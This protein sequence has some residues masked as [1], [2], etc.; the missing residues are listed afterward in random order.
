MSSHKFNH[1]VHSAYLKSWEVSGQLRSYDL[2]RNQVNTLSA[3]NT[4]GENYFYAFQPDPLVIRLLTYTF[5]D[6][7]KQAGAG[8]VYARYLH[9]LS[10]A[11]DADSV[12]RNQHFI[13]KQYDRWE[14]RIG[15]AL[16]E[17]RESYPRPL[18]SDT[19]ESL[20]KLYC[21]QHLR[22]PVMRKRLME[23]IRELTYDGIGLNDSQ[24]EDYFK[25]RLVADAQ[26]MASDI[27]AQGFEIVLYH[28]G[29][30]L[31]INSDSPAVQ[32]VYPLKSVRD[33]RGF[34][35]LSPTM[36]MVIAHVGQGAS[37]LRT[38]IAP[39]SKVREWNH[40]IILGAHAF[41]YFS[42]P[43]QIEQYAE[44]LSERTASFVS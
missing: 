43:E 18:S 36:A 6:I 3:R 34:M 21:M 31:L 14:T 19:L 5:S 30:E 13:E 16:K 35:P 28:T 40:N 17:V 29:D 9:E 44:A 20:V 1:Y 7:V 33:I 22:T 27:I 8:A 24:S 39:A 2:S 4:G 26:A 10:L 12:Q 37:S 42:T 11:T 41:L 15:E 25:I 32:M 23:R 38:E